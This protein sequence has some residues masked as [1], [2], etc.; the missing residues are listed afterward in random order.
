[1]ETHAKQV[2]LYELDGPIHQNI[3][4]EK[5]KNPSMMEECMIFT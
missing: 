3:A 2:E 5:Q 4:K 1:M